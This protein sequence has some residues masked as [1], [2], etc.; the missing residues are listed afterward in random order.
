MAIKFPHAAFQRKP[1]SHTHTHTLKH[2]LI[3][4]QQLPQ[5]CEWQSH[6]QSNKC[7]AKISSWMHFERGTATPTSTYSGRESGVR[8]NF[9]LCSTLEHVNMQ[10]FH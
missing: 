5:T 7:A 1:N 8:L 2:T 4:S 9:A 3:Q 10:I 6:L